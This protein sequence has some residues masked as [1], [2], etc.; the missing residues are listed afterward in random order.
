MGRQIHFHM[1]PNDQFEFLRFVQEGDQVAFISREGES[2]SIMP[3]PLHAVDS[4]QNLYLWNRSLV[5]KLKRKWVRNPG[6]YGINV[7][8]MPILEFVPSLLTTWE[9]KPGLVLGRLYG[10]FDPY[11]RKP[12]G[13]EKWYER[14]ARWIRKA[15]RKNPPGIGGYVAPGAYEFYKS[16]GY[17]LPN[18]R[19]PRTKEWIA[20]IGKQH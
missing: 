8:D 16:G 3:I 5:P 1:L 7:L 13:F 17:L 2:I 9:E 15:C 18:F 10:V 6:F 11:L 19:P 12:P 4:K 14:L 20:E